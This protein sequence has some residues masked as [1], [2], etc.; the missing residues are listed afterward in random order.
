MIKKAIRRDPAPFFHTPLTSALPL[1]SVSVG[2]TQDQYVLKAN[3]LLLASN[4]TELHGQRITIDGD[5]LPHIHLNFTNDS[6]GTASSSLQ[7]DSLSSAFSLTLRTDSVT[8][9]APLH[10]QHLMVND[11]YRLSAS[12]NRLDIQGPGRTEGLT[13]DP[14]TTVQIGA[15]YGILR[16]GTDTVIRPS[17]THTEVT[18]NHPLHVLNED[19]S[20]G[21][22]M[23]LAIQHQRVLSQRSCK[24][25]EGTIDLGQGQLNSWRLTVDSVGRLVIQSRLMTGEWNTRFA[26]SPDEDSVQVEQ[27]AREQTQW[28]TMKPYRPLLTFPLT[29]SVSPTMSIAR[30]L[31]LVFADTDTYFMG[32]IVSGAYHFQGAIP[33]PMLTLPPST[34]PPPSTSVLRVWN[35][36]S[37]LSSATHTVW[38]PGWDTT[39]SS[40]PYRV[41]QV[42]Q[43]IPTT[44]T[45]GTTS[46]TVG[47]TATWMIPR[48]VPSEYLQMSW[49][50]YHVASESDR[51]AVIPPDQTHT[52]TLQT[53]SSGTSS[54]VFTYGSS[55]SMNHV[56]SKGLYSIP[57]VWYPDLPRT[58]LHVHQVTLME[59]TTTSSG[60]SVYRQDEPGA[61]V[62]SLSSWWTVN[63]QVR[64]FL[65]PTEESLLTITLSSMG[66]PV[67]IQWSSSSMICVVS[68]DNQP[69][70]SVCSVSQ[71]T[72]VSG[73]RYEIR[74]PTTND[75]LLLVDTS[76]TTHSLLDMDVSQMSMSSRL[77]VTTYMENPAHCDLSPYTDTVAWKYIQPIS[78]PSITTTVDLP[79]TVAVN[80]VAVNSV[81]VGSLISFS[82]SHLLS[83]GSTVMLLPSQ[84]M[85]TVQRVV[86]SHVIETTLPIVSPVSSVRL[87]YVFSRQRVYP[88]ISTELYSVY[89]GIVMVTQEP[90]LL[91]SDMTVT[92]QL[93]SLSVTATVHA[94]EDANRFV[95]VNAAL[96]SNRSSI[97]SVAYTF[98]DVST[99]HAYLYKVDQVNLNNVLS[100][101]SNH[102]LR[103]REWT[104]TEL[105]SL[106]YVPLFHQGTREEWVF[107]NT[108]AL[109][110][111]ISMSG[112]RMQPMV[113]QSIQQD[114]QGAVT[115]TWSSSGLVCRHGHDT[116]YVPVW[117][118]VRVRC[119]IDLTPGWYPIRSLCGQKKEEMSTFFR[120]R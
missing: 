64:P 20:M 42:D 36:T 2:T 114:Q 109:P 70:S 4:E 53:S 82:T 34:L 49:N 84:E 65:C 41:Y 5:Q 87:P 50:G 93:N 88:I 89:P 103:V 27:Q 66:F 85:V 113:V 22:D 108:T 6:M 13:E 21:L 115:E 8:S 71:L 56:E 7:Y 51:F 23:G 48:T 19:S 37:R 45:D 16:M 32:R 75:T 43:W 73:E 55:S 90:H 59:G 38:T 95:V 9:L 47:T 116:L 35:D 57:P 112:L 61:Q 81:A 107:R 33:S 29:S 118:S 52:F 54:G 86:S 17:I 117:T 31:T 69:Y 15:T 74:F 76:N 39:I 77:S 119:L 94:V 46:T 1:S 83:V 97:A 14:P 106:L 60:P 62:T 40:R 92:I 105:S 101:L 80:S 26:L 68:K 44:I 3:R 104:P 67:R 91:S 78:V 24:L 28:D 120:I 25:S 102:I 30:P 99:E 63:G 110:W 96:Y 111:V 12:M 58:H 10:L 72:I 79:V 98:L 100:S 11:Q 18:M